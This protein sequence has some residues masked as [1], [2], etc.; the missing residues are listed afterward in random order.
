MPVAK[1]GGWVKIPAGSVVL[2]QDP[3]FPEEGPTMRVQV[4]GFEMQAHEVTNREFAAFVAAKAY[5]TDAEK[6]LTRTDGGAG[7]A[8]F[9]IGKNGQP[10]QWKLVPGATWKAPLGPGSSIIGQE[11]KP[12][13]HVS[14]QDAKAYAAWAGGRL[15]NEVE[16]EYAA[17]SGLPDQ[18]NTRS[19]AYDPQKKPIANTWQGLFPILDEGAD[20]FQ[21]TAPV[22][23]FPPSKL[24]LHDMIGNVWEWTETPF[25]DGVSGTVKGGS[26]LC[27]DNFCGRYR[28]Q[29]RQP[30]DTDFSSNHIGFRL[31]RD[32]R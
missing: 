28:P 5:V 21:S 19:G 14:R 3:Y 16:W 13:I 4:T 23:C 10:G 1:Q 24:G 20:G 25:Q 26:W 9:E 6:S 17:Q 7:S 18:A 29:A 27:S 11:D 30:Q 8:V 12:V 2:G 31:V 22:G 15:P 32:A